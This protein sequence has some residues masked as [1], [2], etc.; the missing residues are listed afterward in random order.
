[1]DNGLRQAL[2][3]NE[4]AVSKNRFFIWINNG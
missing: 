4:T 1:M 2:S 3:R